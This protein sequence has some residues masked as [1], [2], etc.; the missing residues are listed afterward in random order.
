MDKSAIPM[1][2]ITKQTTDKLG[3]AIDVEIPKKYTKADMII[4]SSE[5]RK[6][7]PAHLRVRFDFWLKGQLI[8]KET[9]YAYIFYPSDE[10]IKRRL[11]EKDNSGLRIKF[12]LTGQG[13]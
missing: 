12:E 13:G 10:N 6:S 4:I 9:S 8:G 2:L 7:I 1:Y 11:T 3:V 5:L